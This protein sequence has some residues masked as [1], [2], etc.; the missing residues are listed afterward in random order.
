MVTFPKPQDGLWVPLVVS[1]KGSKSGAGDD[2]P[3]AKVSWLYEK[4]AILR[5]LCLHLVLSF[6]PSFQ[7]S[8]EAMQF[9]KKN[10]L[11]LSRQEY[12]I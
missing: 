4:E 7:G 11:E 6:L 1:W 5:C 8:E 2:F 12:I 9:L 3:E 10:S